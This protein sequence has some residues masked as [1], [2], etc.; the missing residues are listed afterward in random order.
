[1]GPNPVVVLVT[2][3]CMSYYLIYIILTIRL[4][5]IICT[6]KRILEFVVVTI[7]AKDLQIRVN[8]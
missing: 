4:S 1:M 5:Y 2:I 8:W 6:G 3:M 7:V